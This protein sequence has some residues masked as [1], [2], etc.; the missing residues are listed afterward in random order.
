M[1]W[2]EIYEHSEF[3]EI[4]VDW[5]GEVPD[6]SRLIAV[7]PDIFTPAAEVADCLEWIRGEQDRARGVTLHERG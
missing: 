5:H 6:R 7:Q 3:G 1:S 4:R 2:C